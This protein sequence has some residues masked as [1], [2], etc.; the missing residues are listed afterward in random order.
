MKTK[1]MLWAALSM[2]AALMMTAC[3]SED[4]QT[5]TSAQQQQG[6]VK[7][8]PYTVTVGQDEDDGTRS[9]VDS[10]MKTLRFAAGDKLYVSGE[11]RTDVYGVLTL[12][13]GDEGKTSGATFEG[14]LNY[15]GNEP[16]S[17]DELRAVLV[18]SNNKGVQITSEGKV[19]DVNSWG[20]MKYP[21]DAYCATV[22]EAVEQYSNLIATST[23]GAKSFSLTQHTAFLN[24]EITLLDDTAAGTTF[25]TVVRSGDSGNNYV[26]LCNANVTT[27]TE[28]GKV[29]AKFVLPLSCQTI[30]SPVVIM[31]DKVPIPFTGTTL[32]A[33][34][35]NVK[36]T[37]VFYSKPLDE[38]AAEDIGK[39]VGKDGRIYDTKAAAE[40]MQT[41]A[42]AMIAYVGNE[43]NCSH[44]L[45]I[46]L[47]NE[48]LNYQVNEITY[49]EAYYSCEHKS[50]VTGGTWRLPSDSD[51]KHIFIGCGSNGTV[52]GA[53]WSVV[54]LNS[55][56]TQAGGTPLNYPRYWTSSNYGGTYYGNLHID[57]EK[58]TVTIESTDSDLHYDMYQNKIYTK[59]P[60]RAC[61]AF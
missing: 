35:Y 3:S 28:G 30:S 24:F 18:S 42:M 7:T 59:Y 36:K 33:K 52:D 54:G 8:I 45:A 12:K 4:N 43:S 61:L 50:A 38:V 48:K 15:T 19:K 20:H 40:N 10:D 21:Y 55:K 26:Y 1:N 31:G 56:L 39:I 22:D 51:W 25:N 29:V 13:S 60:A 27:T 34:V 57:D 16:V 46:A 2:T 37:Q 5:E 53:E 41:Q 49:D 6:T 17:N 32:K 23:Y 11:F 58:G 9:T 44:G 47:D 14:T